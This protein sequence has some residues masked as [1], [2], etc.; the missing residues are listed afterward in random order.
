MQCQEIELVL[1][2]WEPGALP[3]NAA[4]HVA[5]CAD[6]RGLIEDLQAIQ[7][8]GAVLGQEDLEAA[9]PASLWINLRTQLESE[10]LIHEPRPA[11]AGWFD[12]W[13]AAIPRPALA[14]AY[15]ALLIVAGLLGGWKFGRS[16][17]GTPEATTAMQVETAGLS[18]ELDRMESGSVKALEKSDPALSA[19]LRKNLEIVDNFIAVCEKSVRE[20]PKNDLAR[21]YLYGAYHQKADLLATMMERGTPGEE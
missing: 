10:G 3:A 15:L 16:P 13:W 11:G 7:S 21:E 12:S 19:T 14:G 17:T 20:E 18:A 1:E 5:S 4:A 9:P 8:A 6:C 2:Q